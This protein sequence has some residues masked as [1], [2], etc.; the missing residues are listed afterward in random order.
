MGAYQNAQERARE[1]GLVAEVDTVSSFCVLR[2][3]GHSMAARGGTWEEA[4]TNFEAARAELEEAER[5]PARV[6][7]QRDL[8]ERVSAQGEATTR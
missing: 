2:K 3:P 8:F 1:L 5:E 6:V 7:V 4:F